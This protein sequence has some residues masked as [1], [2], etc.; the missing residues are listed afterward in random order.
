MAQNQSESARRRIV[1]P[2]G[3]PSKKNKA[4]F[5]PASSPAQPPR[6]KS[7]IGTILKIFAVLVI[8]AVIGLGLGGFLWWR[9]YQNTPAYSLALL[10][11]A[12]QHNDMPAV[13]KI[14]DT[15]KIVGNFAD[16][17]VEKAANRYGGALNPEVKKNIRTRVPTL[18]PVIKQ[19]LRDELAARIKEVS[20][21]GEQRPFLLI[22]LAMPWVVDITAADDKATATTRVHDQMVKF[23]LERGG[24]GWKVVAVQD[25][26]LLQK[27]V[28]DVMKQLPA[29][30]PGIES[31]IRKR[32]GKPPAALFP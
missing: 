27:L 14:V 31:E 9:H 16:E 3:E 10:V 32:S 11:D 30:A 7:I 25:D 26:A 5:P 20:A 19:Q 6:R 4:R 28:D 17:V 23:D 12:A 1:V 2:L 22:A 18:L 24:E 13:D 8:V 29:I 21:N 15:D